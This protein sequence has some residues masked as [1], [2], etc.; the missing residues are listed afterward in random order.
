VALLIP[1]FPRVKEWAYA[2]LV[3]NYTGA[4]ASHNSAGDPVSAL[5]APA[6]FTPL[7]SPLGPCVRLPEPSVCLPMTTSRRD[8]GP[9]STPGG[10]EGA[11]NDPA[12]VAKLGRR[13]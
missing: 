2:S 12:L 5:V 1:R 8:G 4:A 11:G 9:Q 3:I 6:I 13:A 7:R 10:L